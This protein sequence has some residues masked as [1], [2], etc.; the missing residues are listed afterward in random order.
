MSQP[1]TSKRESESA[2]RAREILSEEGRTPPEP[3]ALAE[4]LMREKLFGL[5]RRILARAERLG[6]FDADSP[7]NLKLHQKLALLTYKDPDLPVDARLDSALRILRAVE[8]LS[9]TANQETLGLAGAVYKRKWEFDNQKPQLERSL[10][11]YLRGYEQGAE[12]DQGYTGINAAYI[13][14]LLAHQEE[15]EA[16]EAGLPSETAPARRAEARR[17]REE[18][19]EKVSPLV[20]RSET[21]WLQGKWWFYATVAEAHFGLGRYDEAVAWLE[22]GRAEAA[23]SEWEYESAARQLASLAHLQSDVETSPADLENTAA[24][25][26]LER[27]LGDD[28]AAVRSAF[29]GKIGLGLSGGGFRASLFHIG[30]L[31]K[32]AELDL[33]RRVEVLSCVSGGSIIGAHYY[34]EVRKLL[35]SAPDREITREDYIALVKR[36]ADSFLKGVQENVRVR[37][38]AELATNLR[39]IFGGYSRT[40]RA[41]E[42]FERDIFSRVQDGEGDSERWLNQLYIRPVDGPEDFYPRRDN[43]RREAKVPIL[44]LNATSLNT[45]HNWHF[46]AS[47]MGEPPAGIDSEIDGNERLRRL[48]YDGEDTPEKYKRMRLGHAVA[49]SACVP[50]LFEPLALDGLYPERVVRLVDGGVCDNQGVMGLLEQD[51][52]VILISDGSGQMDSI[53]D[54]SRGMLGV[55]LRSSTI[56]Q[57][58]VRESQYQDLRARRR[59]QMLRGFVFVHLKEEIGLP[60]VG[61]IGSRETED[62][63]EEIPARRFRAANADPNLTS[64]GIDKKLQGRLA[65]VRTDLDSFS[66]VEAF[67]LMTSAYRMTEQA[68]S[69]KKCLEGFPE[70]TDRVGWDFLAVGSGMKGA[71]ASYDFLMNRLGASGALAFKV[72]KLSK[73]LK[74]L[75]WVLAVLFVL[76]T[77]WAFWTWRD[78]VLVQAITLGVVGTSILFF[79]LSALGTVFVGKTLMRIIRLRETLTLIA[80]GVSMATLGWLLAR[81]HLWV[82]DPLFLRMGSIGSYRRAAEDGRAQTA[83]ARLSQGEVAAPASPPPPPVPSHESERSPTPETK[84]PAP[85]AKP[86]REEAETGERV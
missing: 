41:G 9:S 13:L 84:M 33:L 75:S 64:Y 62:D 71:G 29:T 36:V 66:D 70:P 73:P 76:L 79:V 37:V 31:A 56:L 78:T 21:D 35:Q 16:S 60:P 38:A 69:E 46:T 81:L 15:R 34:L 58:R 61:W 53:N 67:T 52:N 45:G 25:Q 40:M 47:Y 32:L 3:L 57:A 19:I 20:D 28:T 18:I 54:P 23:P 42:L 5:A 86:R 85:E 48:Y 68:I 30:F 51:C 59:S 44:I 12:R 27:F 8:D 55:P 6:V 1:R 2:R 43:W 72:W 10:A 49:A 50:G 4:A 39:M 22:R 82:F 63:S 80:I 77:A 17:I 83:T 65:A 24:W 74:L 14:D 7:D 26:A 11:F